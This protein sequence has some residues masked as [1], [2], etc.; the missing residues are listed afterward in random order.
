MKT[1][2]FEELQK[3]RNNQYRSAVFKNKTSRKFFRDVFA[4]AVGS[5]AAAG[6]QP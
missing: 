1:D 4:F 5:G 2:Y 3:A 6:I